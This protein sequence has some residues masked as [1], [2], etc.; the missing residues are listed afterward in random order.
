MKFATKLSVFLSVILIVSGIVVAFLVYQSNM[1]TL[2]ENE[3]HDLQ[4]IVSNSLEKIDRNLFERSSDIQVLAN[5]PKIRANDTSPEER[6]DILLSFRNSKKSYASLS[7]FDTNRIRI[8]DTSGIDIGK[9]IIKTPYWDDVLNGR[10]SS[11]SEVRTSVALNIP[12]VF[13]A[14]PVKDKD[15]NIFGVVVARMPVTKLNEIIQ[16][17]AKI[18]EEESEIRIDLVDKDG[19]LLLS[20]HDRKRILKDNITEWEY[21]QRPKAGEKIGSNV[22][23]N[24]GEEEMIYVFAK[25]QGYLDFKGN[26]WTLIIHVPTRVAFASAVKLRNK[27]IIIIFPI[28]VLIIILI[29]FFSRT[30]TKPITKLRNAAIQIGKG[31]LNLKVEVNSNDEIGELAKTFNQMAFDLNK[32]QSKLLGL[33]KEKSKE[34]ET[35]V[36]KKTKELTENISEITNTKTAMLN[37]MDD[38]SNANEEL[39]IV[40]KTKG[41]FLNMVSHELKTPL[42][43]IIAHLDVLDDMKTNL[44]E[45][46]LKSFEA[47]R[48]NTNNLK[49]LISNILEISRIESGKFELT[50]IK[51]DLKKLIEDAARELEILSSQK[52]L[53]LVLKLEKLPDIEADDTRLREVMNN[54][55]TNAIKFTEAG[56]ITIKAIKKDK[57]IQVTVEDTGCGIPKDKLKNLFQKFYQVNASISRRYGGTGLGLL[58]TKQLIESHGGKIWIE[59]QEGKGSTF[60]F[61]LPIK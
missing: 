30:I 52:G 19:L 32:Y 38:I 15:N 3:I 53:K 41:E 47:I 50:K 21:F 22:Y 20:N 9:Q 39:K 11:A 29:F 42:T 6:T 34:L 46:E 14:S 23:T 5:L 1:N 61:T 43:A 51:I 25:E 44:T 10:I 13:F 55:I 60:Y 57:F 49:V 48:R 17:T 7:F 16:E 58:I 4:D 2:K 33:E 40:D 31:N 26:N 18:H 27:I 59:S 54:L 8:A 36:N 12:V 56:N 35:E 24:P 28:L 37:I 45:D